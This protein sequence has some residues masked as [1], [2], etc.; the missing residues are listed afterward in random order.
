MNC[1]AVPSSLRGVSMSAKGTHLG[2]ASEAGR[3]ANE[4]ETSLTDALLIN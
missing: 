3:E 1:G 4:I 2:P